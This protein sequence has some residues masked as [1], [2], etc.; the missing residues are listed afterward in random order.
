MFLVEQRGDD[1]IKANR[2]TLTR[3]TGHKQVGYFGQIYHKHFV[4]DGFSQGQRQVHL[5]FLELLRIENAF[6][7]H[8]V[9]LVIGHLYADSAFAWDGCDDANT[10][11]GKA[12]S[13]VVF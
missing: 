13:N 1:G 8:D 9:G 5:C 7:R 11:C 4:G 12:Q 3:C 6:H 2:L 10:Q